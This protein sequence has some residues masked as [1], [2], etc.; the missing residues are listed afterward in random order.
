M[1]ARAAIVTGALGLVLFAGCSAGGTESS[2]ASAASA[3]A[4]FDDTVVHDIDIVFDDAA[5]DEM[6]ATYLNGGDKTWIEAT[7]TIDGTTFKQAGLRLK[8]NSSLRGL[9]SSGT[10]AQGND[11]PGGGGPG[12]SVSAESPQD[13]PWLVSLDKYVDGQEYEGYTEFVVRS[14]NSQSAL[15]EAVA[16]E[17]LEVAGLA[18][19]DSV[20]TRFSVNSSQEVLRLVIENPGD[21]WDDD[22]FSTDGILYKAE[23]SGDYSYR[24]DDPASYAE[25]F[26]QETDEDNEDLA[27]LIDFLEFINTSDDATFAAELS[28]HLDVAAFAKYLAFQELIANSDDIDGPGNNSYLRY[29]A[30]SGVFTVVSWDHNLAF[31]GFGGGGMGAPGGGNMGAAAGAPAGTN[32]G[33]AGGPRSRSNILVERFKADDAFAALYTQALTDLKAQLYTSGKAAEILKTRAA[34][35]TAQAGDLVSTDTVTQ[36]SAKIEAYFK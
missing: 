16:L 18:A 21:A 26:D 11:R 24:G 15:N 7:V 17:L 33:G 25:V 31:G 4:L 20:A 35:L 32:A 3:K 5:Y 13:L 14:N 29:S 27:P 30:D 28:K 34:V 36:E 12:G 6:I 23:S 2:A 10:A 8:G 1:S 22:N 19:E 9:T